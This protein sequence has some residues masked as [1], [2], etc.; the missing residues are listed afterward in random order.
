M[1]TIDTWIP[2]NEIVQHIPYDRNGF[3]NVVARATQLSPN[4]LCISNNYKKNLCIYKKK[5]GKFPFLE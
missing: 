3:E 1:I 4:I 5:G 2:Y